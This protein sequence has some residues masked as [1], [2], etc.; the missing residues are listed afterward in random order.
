MR[1]RGACMLG[2]RRREEGREEGGGEEEEK[3]GSQ[4]LETLVGE[5][6]EGEREGEGGSDDSIQGA[7]FDFVDV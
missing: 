5:K 2:R 7:S 4:G 6:E 1:G 3:T